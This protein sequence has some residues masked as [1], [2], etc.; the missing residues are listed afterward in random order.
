M[1]TEAPLPRSQEARS[2]QSTLLQPIFLTF[3]LMYAAI[4]TFVVHLDPFSQ[5][6]SRKPCMDLS[7]SPHTCYMPHQSHFSFIIPGN[8][9]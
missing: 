5:V 9:S 6:S 8:V 7:C 1:V 4:H 2:I 3:I